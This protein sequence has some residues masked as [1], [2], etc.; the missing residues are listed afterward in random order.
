MPAEKNVKCIDTTGAGDSFV[1]GFLHALAQGRNVRECAEYGNKCGANAV[2]VAGATDWTEKI[3]F[4]YN[5]RGRLKL[6]QKP[7]IL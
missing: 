2:S 7:Q 6:L 4:P 1:A 3:G 5:N